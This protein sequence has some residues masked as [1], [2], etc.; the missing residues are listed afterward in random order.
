M[1]NHKAKVLWFTG[2]SGSGKTTIAEF[3]KNKLELDGKRVLILDGDS[4]RSTISNKLSFS[5][6][7]I[8]TNNLTVAK[9]VVQKQNDFDIIIVPIISPY[10]EHRG[11]VRSTIKDNFSEIYINCTVDEC[12][13]RDTKG[14]YKKALNGQI[15]D[16]IGIAESNP[17]EPP[18][19]ADLVIDTINLTLEDSV[20]LVLNLLK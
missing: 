7:D 17:Y 20:A 1:K 16:M 8:K 3:L 4:I 2:L 12:I 10:R 5:E 11:L 15:K 18:L 6:E 9:L 19:N 14:L 13:N